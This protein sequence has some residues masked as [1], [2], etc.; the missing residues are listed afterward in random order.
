MFENGIPVTEQSVT[1]NQSGDLIC[2]IPLTGLDGWLERSDFEQSAG[3]I[4]P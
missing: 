3:H 1:G 2:I 4:K